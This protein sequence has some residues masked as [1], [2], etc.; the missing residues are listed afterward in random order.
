MSRSEK[1]KQREKRCY[2][3][4]KFGITQRF[5]FKGTKQAS[6]SSMVKVEEATYEAA[7]RRL[8]FYYWNLELFLSLNRFTLPF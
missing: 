3:H 6:Q 5:N 2:I 4:R 7:L 1:S 8:A